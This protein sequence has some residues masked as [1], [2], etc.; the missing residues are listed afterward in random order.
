M[1]KCINKLSQQRKTDMIIGSR[2]EVDRYIYI[3]IYIYIKAEQSRAE[4]SMAQGQGP[5]ASRAEQS[6]SRADS[7]FFK[8]VIISCVFFIFV[9]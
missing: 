6:K 2:G 8:I 1:Y 3:Y 7:L 9:G 5:R 4:Q